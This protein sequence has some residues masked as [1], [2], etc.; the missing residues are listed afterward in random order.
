MLLSVSLRSYAPWIRLDYFTIYDF[1]QAHKHFQDPDWDG[2][3]EPPE[4]PTGGGET[5]R[6]HDIGYNKIDFPVEFLKKRTSLVWKHFNISKKG[7]T[8]IASKGVCKKK[9]L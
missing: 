7:D 1:V 2:E 6:R 4:P 3:P 9:K 5:G 8:F